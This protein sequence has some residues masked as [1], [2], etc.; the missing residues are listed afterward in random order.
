LSN[1]LDLIFQKKAVRG[2]QTIYMIDRFHEPRIIFGYLDDD[3]I[4]WK[5]GVRFLGTIKI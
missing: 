3:P 1:K 5:I 2:I 4:E